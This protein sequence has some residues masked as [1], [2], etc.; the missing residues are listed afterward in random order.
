MS[1]SGSHHLPHENLLTGNAGDYAGDF[2]QALPFS[3]EVQSTCSVCRRSHEPV[4]PAPACLGR[5]NTQ[6]HH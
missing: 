2:G 6:K 3:Y 1:Y 4:T 5:S